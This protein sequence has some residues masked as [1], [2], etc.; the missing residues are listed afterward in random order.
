MMLILTDVFP[1]PLAAENKNIRLPLEP[2]SPIFLMMLSCAPFGV[3]NLYGADCFR[4]INA[5]NLRRSS[6]VSLTSGLSNFLFLFQLPVNILFVTANDKNISI[7]FSF[8]FALSILYSIFVTSD[9]TVKVQSQT[10]AVT[11]KRCYHGTP[12]AAA[13][14]ETGMRG[15]ET[16]TSE[17]PEPEPGSVMFG[18]RK[19]GSV[20]EF[21]FE[22]KSKASLFF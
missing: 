1:T 4:W 12:K 7:F 18:L 6:P 16:E 20:Q 22:Q 14:G 17:N 11:F 2:A 8:F 19:T 10:V 15:A 5:I 3:K 9:R 21:E 13:Q